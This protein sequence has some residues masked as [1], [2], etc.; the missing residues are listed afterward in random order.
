M[1]GAGRPFQGTQG[2]AMRQSTK[3]LVFLIIAVVLAMLLVHSRR[4]FGL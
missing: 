2:V 4:A 3:T 1:S